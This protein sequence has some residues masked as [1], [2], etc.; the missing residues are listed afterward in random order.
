MRYDTEAQL[1]PRAGSLCCLFA[2]VAWTYFLRAQGSE[3]QAGWLGLSSS[4]ALEGGQRIGEDK[5][6]HHVLHKTG[7]P[8]DRVGVASDCIT[9]VISSCPP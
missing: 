1:A 5:A 2:G 6:G 7:S 4:L 3:N 8:G 9:H